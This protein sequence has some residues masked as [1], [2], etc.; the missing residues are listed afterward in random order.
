[1]RW[2]FILPNVDCVQQSS[3]P[4]FLLPK[5]SSILVNDTEPDELS[6]LGRMKT[7]TLS[8]PY[9]KFLLP[10][11]RSFAFRNRSSLVVSEVITRPST[12]RVFQD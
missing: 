6:R 4:D 1:M 3:M 2:I 5:T 10:S 8:D 7:T 9:K 12:R 11:H